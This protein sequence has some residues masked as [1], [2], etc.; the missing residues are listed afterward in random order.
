M[1]G[2]VS[3]RVLLVRRKNKQDIK[4]N[5]KLKEKGFLQRSQIR[6]TVKVEDELPAENQH[7]VRSTGVFRSPW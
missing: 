3:R 5:Y 7:A 1:L 4:S 6:R 2:L